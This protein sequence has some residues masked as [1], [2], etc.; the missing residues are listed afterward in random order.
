V[1]QLNHPSICVL[2]DIGHHEGVDYLVMGLL[3]GETLA[4]RLQRG[5]LHTSEVLRLGAQIADALDRAHR[6]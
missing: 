6:H 3:E 1:S 4:Q 2:H 5:A